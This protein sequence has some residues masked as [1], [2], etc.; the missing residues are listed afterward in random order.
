LNFFLIYH[1]TIILYYSVTIALGSV[2][3]GW[4]VE[5]YG[6]IKEFTIIG[7]FALVFGCIFLSFVG[8][9]TPF[10]AEMFIYL[11]YGLCVSIPLQFSLVIAQTS[12]P[13]ACKYNFF[14]FFFFFFFYI[15]NYLCIINYEFQI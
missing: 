2:G 7:S 10:I 1:F 12:A 5:K 9:N 11:Y 13:T 4:L 14:F 15:K 3:C 6:H 8:E